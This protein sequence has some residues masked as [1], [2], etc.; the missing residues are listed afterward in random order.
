[1]LEMGARFTNDLYIKVSYDPEED[2]GVI[3]RIKND[4]GETY[5]DTD[6]YD[7]NK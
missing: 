7:F 3:T 4:E 6:V 1:M 2:T 5:I